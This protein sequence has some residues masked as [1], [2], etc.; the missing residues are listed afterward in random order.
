MSNKESSHSQRTVT[1]N[2][3]LSSLSA[4]FGMLSKVAIILKAYLATS[5][6]KVG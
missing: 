6:L 2:V 4:S 1:V 5:V 3:S